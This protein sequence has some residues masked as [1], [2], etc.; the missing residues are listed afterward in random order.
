MNY[1][2]RKTKFNL[3]FQTQGHDPFIGHNFQFSK[4]SLQYIKNKKEENKIENNRITESALFDEKYYRVC[5]RA[6]K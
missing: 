1:I 2:Q 6:H 3:C 4:L 5:V